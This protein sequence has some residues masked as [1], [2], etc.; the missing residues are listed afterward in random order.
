MWQ[1]RNEVLVF[2][3]GSVSLG[4][5]F[6][7]KSL[8]WKQLLWL[9][10][11]LF[12]Q[13]KINKK[14]Q[15]RDSGHPWYHRKYP[16]QTSRPGRTI[17]VH[18]FLCL[19]SL[20]GKSWAAGKRY[21]FQIEK[22]NQ[23]YPQINGQE[24]GTE[25][26]HKLCFVLGKVSCPAAPRASYGFNGTVKALHEELGEAPKTPMWTLKEIC[27]GLAGRHTLRQGRFTKRSHSWPHHVNP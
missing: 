15:A 17:P 18:I 9:P 8:I 6:S 19:V 16:Q 20:A 21:T 22:L 27:R 24:S 4:F 23:F 3:G 11:L 26:E 12:F 14:T 13:K 5:M 25:T 2:P 7:I 1:L 10:G